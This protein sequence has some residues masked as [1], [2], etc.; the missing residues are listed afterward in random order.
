MSD[1]GMPE[2]MRAEFREAEV[3]SILFRAVG[4]R[5]EFLPDGELKR[6]LRALLMK[7]GSIRGL[8][9]SRPPRGT[10][11]DAKIELERRVAELRIRP[12]QFDL[13]RRVYAQL[14]EGISLRQE[15]VKVVS[16]ATIGRH[17]NMDVPLNVKMVGQ[18]A[19]GAMVGALAES[20][21]Y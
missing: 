14:A 8:G 19:W 21:R 3:V 9:L 2:R 13:P 1:D 6:D 11:L 17:I 18:F 5:I 4:P 16:G 7:H 10:L 12:W 15:E 20:W